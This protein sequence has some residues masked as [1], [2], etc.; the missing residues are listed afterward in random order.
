M[1]ILVRRFVAMCCERDRSASIVAYAQ[2][3]SIEWCIQKRAEHA[4]AHTLQL[5]K[6]VQHGTQLRRACRRHFDD[7]RAITMRASQV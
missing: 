3:R 6:A 1:R 5:R 2:A 7:R 4:R